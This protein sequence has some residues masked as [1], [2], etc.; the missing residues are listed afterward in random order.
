MLL[1]CDKVQQRYIL[2]GH[3]KSHLRPEESA[4]CE[5]RIFEVTKKTYQTFY[6]IHS[7]AVP[8]IVQ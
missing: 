1:P 4:D 8:H 5:N 7:A 6:T 2:V 3:M